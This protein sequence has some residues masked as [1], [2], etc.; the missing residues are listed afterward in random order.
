VK[1]HGVK[2]GF[3]ALCAGLLLPLLAG[4]HAHL[5]AAQPADGSVITAAPDKFLL[6]FSEA[7]Q[8]TSLSLLKAGVPEPQ[9]I[10]APPAAASTQISI[11]APPLKPGSYELRYRVLSADGHIIS[12]SIHFTIANP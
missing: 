12:G 9:K 5:Q 11:A 6:S 8:L 4:A 2:L 3:A 10:D 7:A 1:P